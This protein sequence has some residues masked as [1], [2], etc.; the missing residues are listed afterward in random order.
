MDGCWYWLFDG[1][2]CSDVLP[3]GCTVQAEVDQQTAAAESHCLPRR[4]L[5]SSKPHPPA[6]PTRHPPSASSRP[7]P[8][9][10]EAQRHRQPG[11][12]STVWCCWARTIQF[13]WG[14]KPA[15]ATLSLGWSGS[16]EGRRGRRRAAKRWHHHEKPGDPPVA[17]VTGE[18]QRSKSVTYGQ[19][20]INKNC[21]TLINIADSSSVLFLIKS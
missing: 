1:A 14:L 11:Q 19:I 5:W 20:Q 2:S 6:S 9:P 12:L 4:E 21:L 8:G 18:K 17:P 7:A 3:A 10:A 13:G 16:G 15:A